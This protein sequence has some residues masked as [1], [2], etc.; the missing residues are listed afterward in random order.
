MAKSTTKPVSK[1]A[2]KSAAKSG[3]RVVR[4]KVIAAER[5][6]NRPVTV[7]HIAK[8]IGLAVSTVSLILNGHG[9]RLKIAPATVKRV[10]DLAAELKYVPNDLARSLRSQR[11]CVIGVVFGN[12]YNGWAQKILEGMLD[13][14]DPEGY[15]PFMTIHNWDATRESREVNSLLQRR[16]DGMICVPIAEG[17]KTYRDIQQR[18][19]PLLLLGDTLPGFEDVSCVSW[20][21]AAAARAVVE[22]LIAIGRRKIGF[23]GAKHPTLESVAR[24]ETYIALLKEHNLPVN[25]DW[26]AKHEVDPSATKMVRGMI[27]AIFK[28]GREI[29]D[30]LYV[31]NDG[32]ALPVIAVLEERGLRIPEDVAVAGM[33]NMP[34]VSHPRINLTTVEEPLEEMGRMSAQTIL[35]L[36]SA[37]E[38]GPLHVHVPSS[39]LLLRATTMGAT[40][41]MTAERGAGLQDWRMG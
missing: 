35:K 41:N 12:L 24:Y 31:L 37:P 27:D 38:E 5:Q 8:E 25:Q 4:P 36:I 13:V 40:A 11:T 10:F 33:G 29:P 34:G 7:S 2:A 18:G 21:S 15:S 26:I 9:P 3:T 32:L 39:R 1:P 14:F 30:A 20:D 16:V 23:I 19:V 6:G 28:P 17:E 22:H